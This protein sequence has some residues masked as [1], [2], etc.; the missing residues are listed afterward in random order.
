LDAPSFDRQYTEDE[1][2]SLA[3]GRINDILMRTRLDELRMAHWIEPWNEPRP[4]S[5]DGYI[6]LARLMFHTC[7]A[8]ELHGLRIVAFSFNNGT[9]EPDEI[10]AILQTGIMTRLRRG[11]HIWGL[12]E[13]IIQ[14][15]EQLPEDAPM[16]W[17][18]GVPATNLH[19]GFTAVYSDAG[20]LSLRYRHWIHAAQ[21]LDI[22]LAPFVITETYPHIHHPLSDLDVADIVA[23]YAAYDAEVSRDVLCLGFTPFTLG[24]SNTIWE[25]EDHAKFYSALV[26]YCVSVKDR[27]N[28]VLTAPP[29]IVPGMTHR[30][31]ADAL[32]VRLNPWDNKQKP[33]P[34]MV[35]S[36][37]KGDLVIVHG[38][39]KTPMMR[40]AWASL[41]DEANE[42]V[43]SRYLEPL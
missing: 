27:S 17:G 36:L 25:Q 34:P 4:H 18:L 19:T 24:G 26:D 29:P 1:L 41:S 23:R 38:F 22:E 28:A 10:R 3:H 16:L 6:Q 2:L 31:T 37:V 30:V 8:A 13:G 5:I 21:E 35:R 7:D 12:H 39:Y 11:R 42:W 32:N 43:S 33:K 14:I 9:P 40:D 20:L 15:P